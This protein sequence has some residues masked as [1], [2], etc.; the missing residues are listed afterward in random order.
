MEKNTPTIELKTIVE[1]LSE[2]E[3]FKK[4]PSATLQDLAASLRVVV[5]KG[6]E[7]LIQQG[8]LDTSMY[9]LFQ[10]R[11]RVHVREEG[12]TEKDHILAEIS[13][14][15]I[16]GEI[17][18]LTHLPRTTTVRAIRDSILL[19]LEESD[20]QR[21]EKIH[22]AEVLEISKMALSRVMT[23]RRAT[24][25]GENVVAITIAPSGNSN[26]RLFAEQLAEKL[27]KLKPTLLITQ[28]T[29]N[30]YFDRKIAQSEF[31]TADTLQ[32]AGWLQSLEKQYGYLIFLTD[33]ELSPWSQRC[34]RQADRIIFVAQHSQ[35]P[36]LNSI[37]NFL[38]SDRNR[39][40]PYIEVVFAHPHD[41]TIIFGT[42][43]WLKNRIF[44]A[45]HH[46]RLGSQSDLEKFIRF[47]TGR[48]FG[49]VLNGG[50]A[51][52]LAHVGAL[53]ALNELKIPIDFIG[54]TSMGAAV[55]AAYA[56]K[57]YEE[58]VQ[59]GEYYSNNFRT[60]WTLPFTALLKGKYTSE[61][62]HRYW[63][64]VCIEDLWTRFF[65]IST[66]LTKAK[67]NVHDSGLV[68]LAV[69]ASTSI[70]GIF[71]PIFDEEGNMLVDGGVMNNMPVDVMRKMI[72]GGEILAINCHIQSQEL[73]K[74][75][76]VQHWISGWNLFFQKL[77]PFSE[78]KNEY[79]SIF[80]IL[81]A[82]LNLS[83][84]AQQ[85]RMGHQAD[86]LLEFD[87]HK[88]KPGDFSKFHQLVEIGYKTTM[89]QLPQLLEISAE[90]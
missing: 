12:T 76:S 10:G 4:L 43:E 26:H 60:E 52:G 24:Q 82:S 74:R 73:V 47:L 34:L 57:T 77:N 85:R 71:P 49:I 72:S 66:N 55:A 51:R 6:G 70:P 67:I 29:C 33:Q 17:A 28:E 7:T 59:F 83:S 39:I 79:E 81:L 37:E 40:L 54:G 75:K 21:L 42:Q 9:I 44:N 31:E 88:F 18:L 87:T 35:S 20:F 58:I 69:R 68:W 90:R 63:D 15:Q 19:K 23:K 84:A 27:Y 36:D 25:S 22:T 64:D 41:Q 46:L 30:Q 61:A 8:D 65:C 50:G 89:E 14:G 11:L 3:L 45:Y 32:I 78:K 86:Y 53:K 5:F 2:I 62:Y 1:F 38:F 13:V 48:A 56:S 80:N 16:V